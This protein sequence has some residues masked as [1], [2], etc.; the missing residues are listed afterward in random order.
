MLAFL[1][2]GQA[3]CGQQQIPKPDNSLADTAGQKREN[4]FRWK[5][6]CAAAA[7]RI[8]RLFKNGVTEVFYSAKRN[9][10]V[11]EV[12]SPPTPK[13]AFL[14]ELY[15]CLTR[16]LIAERLFQAGS[17]DLPQLLDQWQREKDVLK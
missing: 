17:S 4:Q 10:C 3:A 1:M 13:G 6:R 9:S 12:A 5:E 11:C 14:H 7:D 15:D 16:E 2:I 8:D